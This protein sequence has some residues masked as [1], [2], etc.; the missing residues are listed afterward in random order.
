MNMKNLL[1]SHTHTLASGHAYNTIDE[2]IQTAAYKGMQLLGITEHGMAL[3][4]A[5][6]EFYFM[7]LRV[8]PRK[9]HGIEVMYG[10]EA[11]IMDSNGKLD[12]RQGLLE[13]M[14]VVIASMHIPCLKPGTE[15]EN[16]RAAVNAM[17]NPCVNILGHPDDSRY[18]LDYE[19]VVLAAKE[20]NVLLEL[21]NGSL[22][23]EGARQDPRPNDIRMLEL[24]KKHEVS[25]ILNSDAHCAEDIGDTSLSGVLLKEVDFPEH[26]IVNRSVEEYKKYI[27][28]YRK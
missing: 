4:G 1:D 17:K 15:E 22:N 18:P 23:P 3:P 10:V 13:K 26:L 6:H 2:M 24:C 25:V 21:N 14:D 11:N 28:R 7:N 20:Y 8:L 5:C 9:K 27:N 16:T 12:M 19:A